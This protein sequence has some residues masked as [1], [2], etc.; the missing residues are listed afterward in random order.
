MLAAGVNEFAMTDNAAHPRI[1]GILLAAGG[2]S[3]LGV[4]KQFLEYAGESLLARAANAAMEHCSAGLV[5]VTGAVHEPVV[6]ALADTPATIVHNPGWNAG[7]SSS[8]RCGVA[9]ADSSATAYLLLLCDQPRVGSAELGALVAAWSR[10]RDSIAAAGYAGTVGVPAIF[11]ARYRDALLALDGA[12][13][14]R[15]LIVAACGVSV[16][17]MP[18]AAVDI[19]TPD[20]ARR[21]SGSDG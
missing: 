3:R 4:P 20:D 2:S 18:G 12:R 9:A 6:R 7:M 13:G 17:N 15:G 14:A 10:A 16:V 1:A 8:I 19:D 11:P 5:V 21:L